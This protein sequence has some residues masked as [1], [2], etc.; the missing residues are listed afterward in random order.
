MKHEG[1]LPAELLWDDDGHANDVAITALADG[2]TAL[3]PQDVTAHVHACAHCTEQ[4]GAAALLSLSIGE[5]LTALP[6]SAPE[7][8]QAPSVARRLAT[9][10]LRAVAAAIGLAALGALPTLVRF[11]AEISQLSAGFTRSVPLFTK[12]GLLVL[13]GI[14]GEVSPLWL[15]VTLASAVILMMTAVGLTRAL[16]LLPRSVSREVS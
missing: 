12:N 14:Q 9:L 6:A 16:P 8:T 1:T 3:L 7:S 4:L 13:R 5:A 15:G 10:P 2:Q 11:P